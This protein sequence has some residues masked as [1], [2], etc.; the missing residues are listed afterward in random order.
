MCTCRCA[1]DADVEVAD[2][3]IVWLSSSS[4]LDEV[5]WQTFCTL[6]G[7]IGDV[8]QMSEDVVISETTS[9]ARTVGNSP[10]HNGFV[11]TVWA[12]VGHHNCD[13]VLSTQS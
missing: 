12:V 11:R 7:T 1:L 3:Q 4:F 9:F 10:T 8:L 2:H 6:K 13:T 5:P